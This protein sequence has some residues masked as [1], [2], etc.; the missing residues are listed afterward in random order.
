[1]IVVVSVMLSR[2]RDQDKKLK[3]RV[4]SSKPKLRNTTSRHRGSYP[5]PGDLKLKPLG[6]LAFI[7]DIIRFSLHSIEYNQS[8]QKKKI[9][10]K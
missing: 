6:K 3:T 5:R 1:M 9:A 4:G 8:R 7:N 2:P 10:K